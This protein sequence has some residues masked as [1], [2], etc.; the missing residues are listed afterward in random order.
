METRTYN[1][2]ILIARDKIRIDWVYKYL[3]KIIKSSKLLNR[4]V[5][6]CKNINDLKL[7]GI[8]ESDIS[9]IQWN[10]TQEHMEARGKRR[11]YNSWHN[12]PSTT[13]IDYS[14]SNE[15]RMTTVYDTE[16]TQWTSNSFT[17]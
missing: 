5:S 16:L 7:Y 14:F 10:Y 11:N 13:Y 9:E 2:I 3:K 6:S 1:D 4:I 12:D 8:S 15:E 17:K